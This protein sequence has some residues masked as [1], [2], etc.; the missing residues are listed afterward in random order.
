MHPQR[1]RQTRP[2]ARALR[3]ETGRRCRGQT[4]MRSHEP[5]TA[6][7]ACSRADQES[8]PHA[9]LSPDRPRTCRHCSDI[10]CPAGH[11]SRTHEGSMKF[12]THDKLL[13]DSNAE[14]PEKTMLF[15]ALIPVISASHVEVLAN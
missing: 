14:S 7:A 6:D 15:C 2:A 5:E 1:I 9:P 4:S 12:A 8:S 13:G 11:G 3:C 10:R